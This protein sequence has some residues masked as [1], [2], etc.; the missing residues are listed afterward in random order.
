MEN[1]L[2]NK[3]KMDELEIKKYSYQIVLAIQYIH[4]Q[5]ILHRE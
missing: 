3:G 2:R 4:E 5:K 1:L